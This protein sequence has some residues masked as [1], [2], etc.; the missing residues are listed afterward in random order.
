M[1]NC[2]HI[3]KMRYT[4]LQHKVMTWEEKC[5]TE[6]NNCKTKYRGLHVPVVIGELHSMLAPFAR[7]LKL[8]NNK[9]RIIYIMSDSAS[10]PLSFSRTVRLLKKTGVLSGTIT[11]GHAFGGDLECINIYTA[12]I[13]A[14]EEL[15]ADVII[16]NTRTRCGGN[17]NQIWLQ[18]CGTG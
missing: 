15:K 10:L 13:A 16:N 14:R 11:A 1:L 12:L 6:S 5:G 2:G 4:P 9:Y 7:T 17:R 8:L 18:R 3:I